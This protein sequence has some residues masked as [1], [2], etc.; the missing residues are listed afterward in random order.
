MKKK[1][2]FFVSV[3]ILSVVAIIVSI[4]ATSES[5]P[6]LNA[7]VEA[8]A[9]AETGF[10]GNCRNELNDCMFVCS[11]GEVYIS[12]VTMKG[13]SYNISGTCITCKRQIN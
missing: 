12:S 13:P 1:L 6:F 3:T 11:C 4:K 5:D 7:N 10:S 9:G 8:L 2:A